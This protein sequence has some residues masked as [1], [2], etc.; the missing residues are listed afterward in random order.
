MHTGRA[1]PPSYLALLHAGFSVP[2]MR[3]PGGGLL[4]HLF[5]LAKCGRPKEASPRFCRGPAAGC[6][7]HRRYIFC[8]T[9]RGRDFAFRLRGTRDATPWRYQARCP[10]AA[11][12]CEVAAMGVRTFLPLARFRLAKELGSRRSSNS[13]AG[14]IIRYVRECGWRECVAD[15]RGG[16]RVTKSEERSLDFGRDD[17]KHPSAV[18]RKRS[19]A[20][21]AHNREMPTTRTA[22][23]WLP[24][25]AGGHF[26]GRRFSKAASS[27]M[28]T[29]RVLALSNFEPGSLPTTT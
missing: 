22:S 26:A 23:S 8:G 12:S 16:D 13:P 17:R 1:S 19:Q 2:R 14:I 5:T 20:E 18:R 21:N 11:G 27:R 15:C 7:S 3:H 6:E 29:P 10:F 28:G 25:R 4:P 24:G 9:F